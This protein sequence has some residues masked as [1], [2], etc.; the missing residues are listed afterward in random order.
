LTWTFP[1]SQTI[2]NAWG[3]TET[4]SGSAVTFK[5]ANYNGTIAAGGNVTGIG[6]TANG[7][8][9]TPSSFSVNGTK[10]Q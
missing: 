7:S 3:G 1:G 4:Q 6:F 2:S 10:C 5:N 8:A 9:A